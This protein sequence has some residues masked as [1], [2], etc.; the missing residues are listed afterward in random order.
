MLWGFGAMDKK[1]DYLQLLS[2][3]VPYLQF[4]LFVKPSTADRMQ[5]KI[6]VG[7]GLK[8]EHFFSYTGCLSKN[9][10]KH[11]DFFC[12]LLSGKIK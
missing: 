1:W 7:T 5:C 8:S 12:Q 3:S 9:K 10:R 2:K 6:P 4:Y 11:T